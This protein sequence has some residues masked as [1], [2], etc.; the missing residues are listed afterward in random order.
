[1]VDVSHQLKKQLNTIMIKSEVTI[2]GITY[3][4]RATTEAGIKDAIRAIKRAVKQ[5]KKQDEDNA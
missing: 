3:T 2:K 1:V 5:N 4:V